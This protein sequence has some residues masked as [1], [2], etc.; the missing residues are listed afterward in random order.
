MSAR[1]APSPR[2]TSQPSWL[3]GVFG[4]RGAKWKKVRGICPARNTTRIQRIQ[5]GTNCPLGNSEKTIKNKAKKRKLRHS[6]GTCQG[7]GM[8]DTAVV[9]RMGPDVTSRS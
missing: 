3:T 5:R 8:S 6:F 9:A 7:E 1:V 2:N 4:I